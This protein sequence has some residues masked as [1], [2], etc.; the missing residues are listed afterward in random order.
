MLIDFSPMNASK[1]ALKIGFMA[2]LGAG[3]QETEVNI[4]TSFITSEMQTR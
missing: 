1:C 2:N 3:D 4:Y